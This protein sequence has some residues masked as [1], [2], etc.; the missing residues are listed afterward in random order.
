M[1]GSRKRSFAGLAT[2]GSPIGRPRRAHRGRRLPRSTAHFESS[3]AGRPARRGGIR[4]VDLRC[5][6]PVD[7]PLRD[8][9]MQ[10]VYRFGLPWQT[11]IRIRLHGEKP[12]TPDHRLLQV[13]GTDR[14]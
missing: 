1:T 12:A 10:A 7:F 11:V 8:A 5:E 13:E 2:S 4:S 3:R 6:H 14:A 9:A